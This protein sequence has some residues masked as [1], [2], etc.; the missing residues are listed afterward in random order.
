[1]TWTRGEHEAVGL[2]LGLGVE[3]V[4]VQLRLRVGVRRGVRDA[5]RVLE[6]GDGVRLL[7]VG[8]RGGGERLGVRVK[9][10]VVRVQVGVQVKLLGLG[11]GVSRRLCVGLLGVAVGVALREGVRVGVG[12]VGVG[13]A[14]RVREPQVWVGDRLV[15][16]SVRLWDAVG[17]EGEKVRVGARVTEVE[18]EGERLTEWV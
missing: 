13:L 4:R 8:E 14:V 18:G 11:L 5:V 2:G 1:M 9:V 7:H 3:S 6:G 12:G 17:P 10:W 15:G 16:V